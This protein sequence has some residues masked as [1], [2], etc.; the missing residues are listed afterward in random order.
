MSTYNFIEYSKNYSKTTGILWNY[1]RDEPNSCLGSV[2]NNINYSIKNSKS[3]CYKT[4]ITG[5]LDGNNTEKEVE[6]VVRLKHLSNFWRRLDIPLI[7]YE[8]NLILTWYENCVI[9]SKA[10]PDVDPDTNPAVASVNNPT[11]ATFQIKYAKLYVPVVTFSTQDDKK[12]LE[13]LK[14]GFKGTIK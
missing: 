5:E 8:I 6:I 10:T 12:P 13:Q 3:F 11:N 9:T 7:N 14:T 4:S 2:D 1:D